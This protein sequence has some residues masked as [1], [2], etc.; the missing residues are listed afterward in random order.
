MI[1]GFSNFAR[2]FDYFRVWNVG[3]GDEANLKIFSIDATG[4]MLIGILEPM[5]ADDLRV[6]ESA[7]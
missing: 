7:M 6:F 4:G 2:R 5:T 1:E 3:D